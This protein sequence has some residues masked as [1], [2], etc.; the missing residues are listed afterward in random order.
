MN[1][2]ENKLTDAE[3]L[4]QLVDGY[5]YNHYQLSL[6]TLD[7][8]YGFRLCN[9]VTT[10]KGVQ[11][12]FLD[13]NTSKAVELITREINIASEYNFEELDFKPGD[14]VIDIGANVGMVSI[15]LA[16]VYPFLKIYSFEPIKL[17]YSNFVQNI[18]KNEIPDGTII[19]ERKAV[20]GD[21]RSVSLMFNPL[22]SGGS[23]VTDFNQKGYIMKAEDQNIESIT[24]NEIFEKYDIKKVKLLK[25]DCEGAEYEILRNCSTQNL[26]KIEHLRGEFHELSSLPTEDNCIDLIKFCKKYIKNVDVV[27][28]RG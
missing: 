19:H 25:I 22:N 27:E 10:L 28:L 20:T 8:W 18:Q 16:K 3:L 26:K 11:F 6:N 4:R 21:G 17:N 23:A 5:L 1:T 12:E 24:L 2:N 15:Y 14:V 13:A 7:D 9:F